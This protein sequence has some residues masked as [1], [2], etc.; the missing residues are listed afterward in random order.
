MIPVLRNVVGVVFGILIGMAVN[1]GIVTLGPLLIPPPLDA[2]LTTSEGLRA[3]MHLMEPKHFIMPWLAHASG[4]FVG[5]LFAFLVS[6][7]LR[8]R[9]AYIVAFFFF[10]GG[11][12]MVTMVPSPVWFTVT[13]LALAYIPMAYLAIR[14]GS[15]FNSLN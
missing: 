1:M 14:A 4:S 11:V 12:A 5:A 3:S 15:R 2:D 9:M 13:D 7:Y 8:K 10:L 6:A